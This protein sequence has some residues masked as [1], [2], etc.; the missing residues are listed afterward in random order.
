MLSYFKTFQRSFSIEDDFS[1]QGIFLSGEH[2]C[3]LNVAW[4]FE[5]QVRGFDFWNSKHVEWQ[6]PFMYLHQ[7]LSLHEV[8]AYGL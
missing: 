3:S 8:F 2:V 1:T 4:L 5:V 7:L 6:K